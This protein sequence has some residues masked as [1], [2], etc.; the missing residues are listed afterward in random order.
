VP[1]VHNKPI[2]SQKKGFKTK[3]QSIPKAAMVWR[4]GLSGVPPDSIRCTREFD[5]ELASFRNL[6]GR[7]AII[8]RTVRCNTGL[9]GVPAE[10]R[11]LRANDRLQKTLNALQCTPACA[12]VR[13]GAKRRTRQST[14]PVRCTTGLSG[15]PPDCPVSPIVRAPMVG[16]QWPGDVA[17]APDSVR[18]RTRLSGAPFDRSPHQRFFWWLGL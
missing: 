11:L 8:H 10:Q 16:T 13:A 7:S 4:T 17:G 9:S 1:K 6:G 3:E 2:Q 5:S 12:E 14:G 15:A 18:W